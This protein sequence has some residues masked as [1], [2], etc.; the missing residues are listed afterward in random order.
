M[1]NARNIFL[2]SMMITLAV[3]GLVSYQMLSGPDAIQ[4]SGKS[5]GEIFSGDNW[6]PILTIPFVILIMIVSILPFFRIM[7]PPQIKN[8]LAA[9]ATVQK[10]WDTGTTINNNPQVGLLLNFVTRDGRHIQAETKTV[11]SRLNATLIRPGIAADVIYDPENIK[12]LQVSKLYLDVE[13]KGDGED[14]EE[15]LRQL[16]DL[17]KKGLV[18]DE[19]YQQQREAIIKSI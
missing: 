11:V 12:R 14:V 16:D 9:K 3:I 7:F 10:V 2:I 18:T 17:H 1:K 19:E 8:G 13:G 4:L 15:R 6:V 5:I